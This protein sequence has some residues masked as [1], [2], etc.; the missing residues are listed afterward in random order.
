[1][2]GVRVTAD[3]TVWCSSGGT[4]LRFD[5][6]TFTPCP[7][8]EG[9]DV[10]EHRFYVMG[11][12]L[13]AEGT[14]WSG[15]RK[16]VRYSA[17]ESREI[18]IWRFRNGT[19]EVF[20]ID[21]ET[22]KYF[23][24]RIIPDGRGVL[25]LTASGLASWDGSRIR[26]YRVNSPG[27]M[28]PIEMVP[29]GDNI[30]ITG[31]NSTA[32]THVY[33]FRNGTWNL[34]STGDGQPVSA[35][36]MRIDQQNRKWFS[37]WDIQVSEGDSLRSVVPWEALKSQM[38]ARFVVEGDEVLWFSYTGK[39][40][41]RQEG[42]H[43]TLYTMADGLPSNSA[44]PL[45]MGPD[46]V[47]WASVGDELARFDGHSWSFRRFSK[48]VRFIAFGKD[49]VI[50]FATDATIIRFDG[51]N[52]EEYANVASLSSPS[53][54]SIAVDANGVL[55]ACTWRDGVLRYD[56]REWTR[57]TTADGL[58]AD[59]T[60]AVAVDSRNRKWIATEGGICVLDDSGPVA[61]AE[62]PP[63]PFAFH[64]NFPNPFNPSTTISFTLPEAGTVNLAIYSITGQKV[65]TLLL[66]DGTYKSYGTHKTYTIIWDGRDDSGVPV[67]S[68]IYLCRL[69]QGNHAA[70]GRMT[71]VK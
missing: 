60:S 57:L 33:Q 50:W 28:L 13:D 17:T 37:M 42:D 56:G 24:R 69:T 29:E 35:W 27:H 49:G 22:G 5:G 30:W 12:T 18:G 43:R 40:L 46:G 65:R 9:E 8:P 11:F 61:I 45:G 16:I 26:E 3:G 54:Q 51:A 1:M 52:W 66:D 59:R 32:V 36:R 71:L 64:G 15:V 34:F 21:T 67:S 38:G 6:E 14:I 23:T 20:P 19:W 63:A 48:G 58:L 10:P 55:W 2:G 25:W 39:G 53:F 41:C 4:L 68:G 44:T 47:L 62:K 31:R 70:V 7:P